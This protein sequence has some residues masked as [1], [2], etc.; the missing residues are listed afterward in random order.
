MEYPIEP[1]TV[2]MERESAAA[3]VITA[4]GVTIMA[5]VAAGTRTPPTP[6]EARAPRA[7]VVLG[8]VGLALARAPPK[9]VIK[10]SATRR[11]SRLRPG[12]TERAALKPIAPIVVVKA[13]G[14]P[15]RPI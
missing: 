3:V 6:N 7:T 9:A 13:G 12:K 11:I 4:S 5:T 8:L 1:P 14:K 2:R 10:K 15:L